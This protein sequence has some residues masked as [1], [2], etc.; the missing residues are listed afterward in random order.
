MVPSESSLKAMVFS[1]ATSSQMK[2]V[3]DENSENSLWKDVLED[4]YLML[5]RDLCVFD[6]LSLR[7]SHTSLFLK[8]RA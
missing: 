5:W 7:V 6:P 1:E 2:S 8:S 4:E 3:Y